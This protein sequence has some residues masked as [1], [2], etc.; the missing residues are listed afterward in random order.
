MI[1]KSAKLTRHG[2]LETTLENPLEFAL[3]F[4]L[5]GHALREH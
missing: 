5:R 1:G 4:V 2:S 3:E